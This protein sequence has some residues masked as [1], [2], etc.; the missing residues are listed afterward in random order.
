MKF[1]TA[2]KLR[3]KGSACCTSLCVGFRFC[4]IFGIIPQFSPETDTK[5]KYI[6]FFFSAED[7][8]CKLELATGFPQTVVSSSSRESETKLILNNNN[9]G[10]EHKM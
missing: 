7:F 2:G 10:S 9:G 4:M 1:R 8:K 3:N 6:V 5:V